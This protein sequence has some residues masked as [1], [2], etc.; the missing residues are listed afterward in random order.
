MLHPFLPTSVQVLIR[1]ARMTQTLDSAEVV[2]TFMHAEKLLTLYY[3]GAR[4]ASTTPTGSIS[5]A[6]QYLQILIPKSGK[7]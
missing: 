6:Y 3:L 7:L 2:E 4:I 5:N 1:V